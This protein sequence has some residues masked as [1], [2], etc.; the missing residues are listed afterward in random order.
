MENKN[1]TDKIKSKIENANPYREEG[2][3]AI[4]IE[5]QTSRLPSHVFLLAAGGLMVA[6]LTLK[7]I[8]KDENSLFIGQWVAPILLMGLYNKIV[9]TQGHDQLNDTPD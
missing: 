5:T 2:K 8:R 9:K 6:S 7:L 1:V 3:L 4:A